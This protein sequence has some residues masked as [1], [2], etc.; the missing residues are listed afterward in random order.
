MKFIF[1]PPLP[2]IVYE[3]YRKLQLFWPPSLPALNFELLRN[4]YDQ[5]DDHQFN[6]Y[7]S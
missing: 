2:G 4:T 3:T 1:I 7:S 5:L 6:E